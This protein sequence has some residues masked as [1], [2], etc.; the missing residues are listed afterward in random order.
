LVGNGF[1]Q[2]PRA[3]GAPFAVTARAIANVDADTKAFLALRRVVDP[4][5]DVVVVEF[6]DGGRR[7]RNLMFTMPDETMHL[8]ENGLD[9]RTGRHYCWTVEGGRTISVGRGGFAWLI[10]DHH[11]DDVDA[12]VAR[13]VVK[14]VHL[15]TGP[16]VWKVPIGATVVG[17]RMVEDESGG[18]PGIDDI[19]KVGS[20]DAT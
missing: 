16:T 13:G 6:N 11:H 2:V 20:R 9:I 17:V 1:L 12:L 5:R 19:C 14:P 3:D 4:R 7:F 15:A 8:T 10:I 18:P